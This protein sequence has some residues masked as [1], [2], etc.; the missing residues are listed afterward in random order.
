MMAPSLQ[1]NLGA[2]QLRQLNH[3]RDSDVKMEPV[4]S[5][6]KVERRNGTDVSQPFSGTQGQQEQEL[7]RKQGLVMV[8]RSR[9]PLI[10]KNFMKFNKRRK[11]RKKKVIGIPPVKPPVPG[12][13]D[14]FKE[15][16]GQFPQPEKPRRKKTSSVLGEPTKITVV[17][18]VQEMLSELTGSPDAVAMSGSLV[19][20]RLDDGCPVKAEP[21]LTGR[22]D[23]LQRADLNDEITKENARKEFVEACRKYVA[24]MGVAE[25]DTILVVRQPATYD[26]IKSEFVTPGALVQVGDRQLS[27]KQ[28]GDRE[29]GSELVIFSG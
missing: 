14:V 17:P 6:I 28:A 21:G 8:N 1:I 4:E 23:L 22:E 10:Q 26:A 5:I 2:P 15:L 7:L 9:I 18:T 25:S 24:T 29:P 27:L 13:H 19:L 20:P 16:T 3:T 11:R 12:I